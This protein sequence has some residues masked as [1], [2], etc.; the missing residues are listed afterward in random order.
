[1]RKVLSSLC[2]LIFLVACGSAA[3]VPA[4]HSSFTQPQTS[5]NPSVKVWVNTNSG[6]YHCP[7]THWYGNTKKGEYMTQKQAQDKGYRPARGNPCQ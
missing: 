3:P 2:L 7:G 6:V 4:N 1:M 5:G